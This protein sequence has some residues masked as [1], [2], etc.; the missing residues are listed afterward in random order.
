MQL[1]DQM[2]D[3]CN[4]YALLET[5]LGPGGVS[6]RFLD[7]GWSITPSGDQQLLAIGWGRLTL[8]DGR[9][10]ELRGWI[11][12]PDERVAEVLSLLGGPGLTSVSQWV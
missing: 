2:P 9:P 10:M 12:Q 6:R 8:A 7:A 11:D 1:P 5:E 4:F 3:G